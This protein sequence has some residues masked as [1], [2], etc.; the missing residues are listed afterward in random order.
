M[1]QGV[2]NELLA[3]IRRCGD[4]TIPELVARTDERPA[5]FVESLE[6]LVD[7]ELISITPMDALAELRAFAV[8]VER[9]LAF[10]EFRSGL[11]GFH[12]QFDQSR[13]SVRIKYDNIIYRL[14]RRFLAQSKS[15]I[16]EACARRGDAY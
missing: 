8:D 4:L 11:L 14:Q 1:D 5:Q 7:R 15:L 3:T 6:Q 2:T 12:F 13:L 9:V 16:L 10:V